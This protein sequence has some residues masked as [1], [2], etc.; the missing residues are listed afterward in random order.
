L[1]RFKHGP[2]I[3]TS[4]AVQPVTVSRM[5]PLSATSCLAGTALHWLQHFTRCRLSLC[6]ER[7]CTNLPVV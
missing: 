1:V 2:V 4:L 7:K 5:L 6:A 3:A